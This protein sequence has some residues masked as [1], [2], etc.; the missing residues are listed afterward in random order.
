MTIT[1]CDR[2]YILIEI[3]T[4]KAERG[5]INEYPPFSQPAY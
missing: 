5:G 1:D 3:N 2:R 4:G